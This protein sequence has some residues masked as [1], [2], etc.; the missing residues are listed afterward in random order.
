MAPGD[1][2][3][4]AETAED[5]EDWIEEILG[6]R[7]CMANKLEKGWSVRRRTSTLSLTTISH[8]DNPPS[9]VPSRDDDDL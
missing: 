4:P 8:N 5:M 9:T 1:E 7:V 6:C 2:E 3:E